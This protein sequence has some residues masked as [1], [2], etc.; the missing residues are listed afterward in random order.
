MN[1]SEGVLITSY[2]HVQ[3]SKMT[4]GINDDSVSVRGLW[5]KHIFHKW[6]NLLWRI[7]AQL[8]LWNDTK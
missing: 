7:D 6:G 3:Q 5:I 2:L 4:T 8:A 1:I